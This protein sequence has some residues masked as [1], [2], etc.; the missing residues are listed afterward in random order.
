MASENVSKE[1]GKE[2]Y[3]IEGAEGFLECSGSVDKLLEQI[4]ANLRS[5]M[6]YVDSRNLF[7]YYQ[8]TELVVVSNSVK[9][10]SGH[11]LILRK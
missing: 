2:K 7:Q 11:Q 6:S 1:S 8:N 3:S 10:E 9:N 5:S 4:E